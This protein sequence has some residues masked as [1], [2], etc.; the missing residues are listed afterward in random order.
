MISNIKL[1]SFG[2]F[3]LVKK[4]LNPF[5]KEIFLKLIELINDFNIILFSFGF[6]VFAKNSPKINL[7]NPFTTNKNSPNS[8]KDSII[9]FDNKVLYE[10]IYDFKL[11]QKIAFSTLFKYN[12][13][14]FF[15][16]FSISNRRI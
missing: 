7:S 1:A 15:F 11:K 9:S 8:S 2:K 13:R 10:S 4:N 16:I 14:Y 5:I 12:L 6:F 3:N